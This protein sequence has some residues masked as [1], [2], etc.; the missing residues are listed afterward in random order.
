M[1]QEEAGVPPL[2]FVQLL[3]SDALQ[4]DAV[5]H[6]RRLVRREGWSELE[7]VRR[8]RQVPIRWFR[9]VFADLDPESA[10]RFGLAFAE[11]AQLTS[12]GPL[13]L[14]LI[15]AASVAEVFDLLGYLPVIS[16]SLR[17]HF[18]QSPTSLTVGLAGQTDD[19]ALNCLVIAYGGAALLRLLDMLAGEL[20]AVTLHLAWEAPRTPAL[21]PD[22][23][24]GRLVFGAHTSFIDVPIE[25]LSAP[26]RFPDPVAYRLAITELRR[27]LERDREPTSISETIRRAIEENPA[28]SGRDEVAAMLGM[29]V[30]T[31]K[32]RLDAEGTTFR[33]LREAVLRER[34]IVRLLDPSLPVSQIAIDLGYSDLANFSHAFKRWTGQSPV[35]FRRAGSRIRTDAEASGHP[36][37]THASGNRNL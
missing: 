4:P 37:L 33:E 11:Q 22:A 20:P 25:S 2:A 6:F 26:C 24:A 15:S 12:F 19:P 9:E 23:V 28:H 27:T 18:H 13:S 17:P 29:S 8:D 35:A 21:R 31:V 14:P 34:A 36:P 1:R 5:A 32:R 3:N 30:S 16:G 7:L 10:T